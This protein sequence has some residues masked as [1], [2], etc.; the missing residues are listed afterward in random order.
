MIV[1][2]KAVQRALPVAGGARGDGRDVLSPTKSA[3]VSG[4]A[5]LTSKLIDG[6]FP[7]YNRVIP[8]G[9]DKLLKLDPKSFSAG[10]DRVSTIAVKRPARLR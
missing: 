1:P 2:R 7:D 6:T 10:V 5:I 3:S 9:N 4:S 8:T